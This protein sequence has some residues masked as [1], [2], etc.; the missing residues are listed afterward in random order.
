MQHQGTCALQVGQCGWWRC[1]F[2]P[3]QPFLRSCCSCY[4]PRR[5]RSPHPRSKTRFRCA[6]PTCISRRDGINLLIMSCVLINFQCKYIL[7]AIG[8][9]YYFSNNA[10]RFCS[11][12]LDPA[13]SNKSS[14]AV[15]SRQFWIHAM[16]ASDN[17]LGNTDEARKKNT[18]NGSILRNLSWSSRTSFTH[19]LPTTSC[20]QLKIRIWTKYLLR[21]NIYMRIYID[22]NRDVIVVFTYQ[23]TEVLAGK[24]IGQ[25][26]ILQRPML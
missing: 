7:R 24:G 18:S 20:I 21:L 8:E 19:L 25:N 4:T 12:S 11:S 2:A 23:H 5:T 22:N 15:V 16:R 13:T 9:D 17:S 26:G 1:D 6:H 10:M 14:T 3:L